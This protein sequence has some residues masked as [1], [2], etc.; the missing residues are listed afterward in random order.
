MN[1]CFASNTLLHVAVSRLGTT[2]PNAIVCRQGRLLSRIYAVCLLIGLT[3]SS[4]RLEVKR[5]GKIGAQTRIRKQKQGGESVKGGA[6]MR[7]N[8]CYWGRLCAPSFAQPSCYARKTTK[9]LYIH[10]TGRN[11]RL[12]YLLHYRS[13]KA[14]KRNEH[15]RVRERFLQGGVNPFVDRLFNCRRLRSCPR[16]LIRSTACPHSTVPTH[17]RYS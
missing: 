3:T 13:V 5:S 8:P 14:S 4:G 9:T 16:F 2:Q 7:I 11:A 10:V 15:L 12:V 6:N 1:C 17:G